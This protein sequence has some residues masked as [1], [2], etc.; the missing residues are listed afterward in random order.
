ML[1][2]ADLLD[3]DEATVDIL[4]NTEVLA[5]SDDPLGEEGLRLGDSG[6]GDKSVGEIYVAPMTGGR[7]AVCM[8]NRQGGNY[9]MTFHE[10]D[11]RALGATSKAL[12]A[13]SNALGAT[14]NALGATSKA[15]GATSKALGATS[16][17]G[18]ESAGWR[19]RDVWAHTDNGT[20]STDAVLP[21]E[22]PGEDV[23]MLVLTPIAG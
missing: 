6:R 23:V 17:G 1:I 11:L 4:A 22:V 9:S 19:V 15:L 20:L 12:G 2:S 8:F 7:F 3:A 16:N 10:S 13:T 14:S 5:V 18:T 21:V